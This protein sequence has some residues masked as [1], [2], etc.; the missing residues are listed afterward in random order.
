MLAVCSGMLLREA[1]KKDL[2]RILSLSDLHNP[3]KPDLSTGLNVV[4][5]IN[6]EVVGFAKLEKGTV[7]SLIV[8]KKHRRKNY[9][10]RA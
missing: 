3:K 8:L 9:E 7:Y 6:N 4:A 1:T 10:L 5:L 2:Q